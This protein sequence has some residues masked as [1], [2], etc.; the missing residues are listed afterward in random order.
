M[1]EKVVQYVGVGGNIT[2]GELSRYENSEFAA[3][4]KKDGCWVEVR[5]D[6]D[7]FIEELVGRSG[8]RFS[9]DAVSGL[10]GLKT[11]W[12]NTILAG[13]LET[14]TESATKIHSKLGY[15]RI[16]LFDVT[17]LLG[18][19]VLALDY[20]TRRELLEAAVGQELSLEARKRLLLVEQVIEGF[21]AFF[22]K[23]TAE[24]GEG[25]VLKRRKSLYKQTSSGRSEHWV[26][27]KTLRS[28]DYYVTRLE[29]TEKGNI[30]LKLA[31]Y[32]NG[33]FVEVGKIIAPARVRDPKTL[34][35]QVVECIGAELHDSGML[36]HARFNRV[37]KDKKA[38]ECNV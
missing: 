29:R 36:R 26:R 14:A 3:E 35:G 23:V 2:P 25:L 20:D 5:T 8:L 24:D 15:R 4:A 21:A 22:T 1:E 7:G 11:P 9:G 12:S 31:L 18:Q 19:S 10:I 27:C 37:R 16:W 30:S 34:V 13:E 32:R 28:V 6:A 33:E 38:E 17:Q